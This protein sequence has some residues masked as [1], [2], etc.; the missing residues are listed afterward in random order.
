MDGRKRDGGWFISARRSFVGPPC[1]F[2]VR[3]W[4]PCD[5][6]ALSVFCGPSS[7]CTFM[8][9]FKKTMLEFYLSKH[10]WDAVGSCLLEDCKV[11][12]I[13]ASRLYSFHLLLYFRKPLLAILVLMQ[14]PIRI[15][16]KSKIDSARHCGQD[17]LI[18]HPSPSIK[19]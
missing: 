11:P 2:K 19:S 9:T 3:P 18:A 17:L 5:A 12:L 10:C 15:D 6:R 1:A 4:L 14:S 13:N 7:W 8:A 16:A